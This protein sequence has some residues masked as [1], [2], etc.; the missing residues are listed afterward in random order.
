MAGLMS[1]AMVALVG[2]NKENNAPSADGAEATVSI[3][4]QGA[5]MR[6]A[7]YE[8]G[9]GDADKKIYT[10]AAMVYN[11]DVQEAYKAADADATEITD[12]RCTAGDRKLV[13]VANFGTEKLEG[14]SLTEL[15]AKTL[16]LAT[17]QQNP[18][19]KLHMMT[20]E[21]QGVVIAAGKNVYGK[22]TDDPNDNEINAEKPLMITHVHAGMEFQKITVDFK[23][24]FAA[25]YSINLEEQTKI[26]G[27]IVKKQS[28]IFGNPL[29]FGDKFVY[30]EEHFGI[31]DKKYT[32]AKENYTEEVSLMKPFLKDD[33]TS[34]GFYILE[35]NSD[36]HPTILTLKTPLLDNTGKALEGTA[37]DQ[38]IAAGY[39][40]E[41]GF[42]YYPVLVNWTKDGYTYVEGDNNKRNVIERNH[43]YQISMNITG[44]GT[45]QP[46]D[47]TNEPAT[48]D[49]TITVAPW[50]LVTQNVQW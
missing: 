29:A 19:S 1:L 32:P 17:A 41:E 47:P 21:V 34:A 45:N 12:I 46:E 37:K 8:P 4:L 6:A 22:K 11:G 33:Y 48:L 20:S 36:K 25:K 42:T 38:A 16:E 30:G 13:V 39:C 10:L 50:V 27:L 15:Q 31:S 3:K 7:T 44:P 26:I 23:S 2:C 14:L 40:D 28:K 5:Q 43:K 49:V 24:T 9:K 35:N 18:E